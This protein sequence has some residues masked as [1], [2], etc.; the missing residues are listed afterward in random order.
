VGERRLE[1]KPMALGLVRRDIIKG[2]VLEL[3][4]H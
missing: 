2:E 1:G 4:E 3:P